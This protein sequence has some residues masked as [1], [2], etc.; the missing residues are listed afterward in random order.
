MKRT[1]STFEVSSFALLYRTYDRCH[2]EYCVQAWQPYYKKD[3]EL[4]EKIQRSATRL[5]PELRHLPCDIRLKRLKITT[6][7]DKRQRGGLIE[8]YKIISGKENDKCDRCFKMS[9]CNGGNITRGN[10]KKMYKPR[11]NKGILQR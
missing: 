6:L 9:E 10:Y 1:F 5:V 3:I 4:L 8:A 7:E 2:M 11:L